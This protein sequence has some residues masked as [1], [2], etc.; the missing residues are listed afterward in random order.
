MRNIDSKFGRTPQERFA[1]AG[2]RIQM[3][4]IGDMSPSFSAA[5]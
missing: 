5:C 3:L 1:A 2:A 4:R